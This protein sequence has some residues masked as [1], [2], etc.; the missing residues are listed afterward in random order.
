MTT[1]TV[2]QLISKAEKSGFQ[3]YGSFNEGD[4]IQHDILTCTCGKFN[5]EVID[6]YYDFYTGAVSKIEITS[7]FTGQQPTFKF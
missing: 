5:G 6:L 7:Q 2:S 3:S 1:Q 4:D